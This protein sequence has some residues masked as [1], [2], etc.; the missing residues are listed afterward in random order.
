MT[1]QLGITMFLTGVVMS[2][3]SRDNSGAW[4]GVPGIFIF[5]TGVYFAV[6][7]LVTGG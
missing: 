3:D 4:V 2:I 5:T 1:M 7:S 6:R